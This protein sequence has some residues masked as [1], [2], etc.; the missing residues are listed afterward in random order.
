MLARRRYFGVSPFIMLRDLLS[1][2]NS[3]PIHSL[4]NLTRQHA[5]SASYVCMCEHIPVLHINRTFAQSFAHS[6]PTPMLLLLM[7][8]CRTAQPS[9]HHKSV[10]APFTC[11]CCRKHPQIHPSFRPQLNGYSPFAAKAVMR[12]WLARVCAVYYAC[13]NLEYIVGQRKYIYICVYR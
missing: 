11:W 13:H 4:A 2:A 10:I 7:L 12:T 3:Q 9:G 1:S 5:S 6:I 8:C